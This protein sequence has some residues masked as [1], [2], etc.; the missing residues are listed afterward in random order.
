MTSGSSD[1]G[2][3]LDENDL[4]LWLNVPTYTYLLHVFMY[5]FLI[6]RRSKTIHRNMYIKLLFLA[7]T[8]TAFTSARPQQ[9]PLSLVPPI[10]QQGFVAPPQNNA[11]NPSVSPWD[12]YLTYRVTRSI[13]ILLARMSYKY[14]FFFLNSIIHIHMNYW[15][16]LRKLLHLDVQKHTLRINTPKF[17]TYTSMID[18]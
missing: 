14:V 10:Q 3:V 16:P 17:I 11:I 2:V 15:V 12:N 7:F 8:I 4:M 6:R 5:I 13:L 1:R 9:L 18:C